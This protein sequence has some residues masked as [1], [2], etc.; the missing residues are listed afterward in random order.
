[1]NDKAMEDQKPYS[2]NLARMKTA[3]RKEKERQK[4]KDIARRAY[5]S[6]TADRVKELD[7]LV[8]ECLDNLRGQD[9]NMQK[10]ALLYF[11]KRFVFKEHEIL[12]SRLDEEMK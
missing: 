9:R 3:E 12:N 4:Q 5:Q 2:V 6:I 11:M 7:E 1:M 10:K 8:E